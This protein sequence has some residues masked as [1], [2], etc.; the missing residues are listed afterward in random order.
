MGILTLSQ[1]QQLFSQAAH[2]SDHEAPPARL[3]AG[4]TPG[5]TLSIPDSLEVY[6]RGFIVR[7]T[8]SLGEIYESVWWVAG[9]EEFFRLA[10]KFILSQ[11]S[12]AYN[13]SLYG[14]EFP[15]FLQA[16]HPFPDLPFLPSLAR[17]EW[18]FKNIFHSSQHE[19]ISQ[20]EIQSITQEGHIQFIFGSSV[21]LFT[22]PFAVYD[23]WKVRGTCHDGQP[24]IEWNHAQRLLLYKKHDQIFVNELDDVEYTILEKLLGGSTLESSLNETAKQYPNLEQEQISKLFQVIF[25]TGIIHRLSTIS[26]K[27]GAP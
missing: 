21:S 16:E 1:Y 4:M 25:H 18:L 19:S 14:Q 5:G 17:F 27:P 20:E 9:D 15:D 23:L 26:E 13:L 22:A 24:P 2:R 6:R 7:L 8:E 12:E 3:T 11:H 10:K